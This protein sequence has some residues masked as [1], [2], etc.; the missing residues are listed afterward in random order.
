[1]TNDRALTEWF[2]EHGADPNATC[3][4]DLT[5]MSQAMRRAPLD[6]I[7]IL[8]DRGGDLKQGQL[9]HHA[10]LR[11]GPDDL[12]LVGLLLD[13]GLPINEIQYQNCP[14]TFEEC[15][16]FALGTPLHYAAEKG[17]PELVSLLLQRGADP[18]L[19]NTK[20]RTGLETAIFL[21]KT[22][23]ASILESIIH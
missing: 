19:K 6:I 12:E 20:G 5:P 22:E 13:I 9:L 3:A 18:S 2:L 21:Q 7:K 16:A 15:Y 8:F 1:M 14:Q 11:E 4:W 23:V 10:V 17:K